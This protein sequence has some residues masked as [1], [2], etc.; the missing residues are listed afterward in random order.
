M[1]RTEATQFFSDR[2][3]LEGSTGTTIQKTPLVWSS[4][5]D[6]LDSIPNGWVLYEHPEFAAM[7]QDWEYCWDMYTGDA[8]RPEKVEAYLLQRALGESDE[9][10]NE[11]KRNASLSPHYAFALDALAGLL[12]T[13]ETETKR[14]FQDEESSK[15]L[16]DKDEAGTPA[17]SLWN[18]ADGEGTNYLPFWQ[19]VAI[20]LLIFKRLWILAQGVKRQTIVLEDG[21]TKEI[22]VKEPHWRHLTPMAVTNWKHNEQNGRLET[23]VVHTKID[24]RNSIESTPQVSDVYTVYEIGGWTAYQKIVR[25]GKLIILPYDTGTY[26]YSERMGAELIPALPIFMAELPM[27]RNVS[28]NAATR[29]NANWNMESERDALLRNGN[30]PRFV[31]VAH[32]GA[33]K[34]M[35]QRLVKGWKL[36][37]HDPEQD[38]QHYYVSPP[39]EA[40]KLSTEVL[41]ERIPEFYATTFRDFGDAAKERTAT[42]VRSRQKSGIEA[43]LA[44]TV[45]TL[46]E[47][48][49]RGLFLQEQINFPDDRDA[50]GQATATYSRNFLPL[51][52]GAIADLIMT[53]FF[54]TDSLPA[55][56]EATKNAVIYMLDYL[57]LQYD[58]AEVEQAVEERESA[59]DR[60]NLAFG[61]DL[62]F[63]PEEL[64]GPAE[65]EIQ[66]G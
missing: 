64:E 28:L 39:A 10:Y 7:Y 52:P 34:T 14:Q 44:L 47:A 50:W 45:G 27:A 24:T 12:A 66:E 30:I 65:D 11:R 22:P 31:L 56:P 2:Q 23:V 63:S 46:E 6:P 51:E 25:N 13:A 53:S 9:D 35:V 20:R 33:Y 59:N 55:G 61:T 26:E 3:G 32:E 62:A 21:T 42:E 58:E 57:G 17:H 8:A 18:N 49:N 5:N 43:A 1:P 41:K 19:Q 48:E 15:G 60:D 29:A 36:L 37:R 4:T 40:A 38:K 54:P 16:G